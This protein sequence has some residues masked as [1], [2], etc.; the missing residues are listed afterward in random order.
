MDIH[1]QTNEVGPLPYTMHKNELKGNEKSKHKSQTIN[2]VEENREKL[3]EIG[4]ANDFLDMAP[5]SQTTK[6]DTLDY[7]KMENFC[8]S[9]DTMKTVMATQRLAENICK[10]YLQF[11]NPKELKPEDPSPFPSCRAPSISW[12]FLGLRKTLPHIPD[13][14]H[15]CHE[16]SEREGRQGLQICSGRVQGQIWDLPVTLANGK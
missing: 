10:S 13:W 8:A 6:I 15:T 4:F 5:K 12:G 16:N 11:N 2:V 14:T 3:L 9:E 1:L 7:I